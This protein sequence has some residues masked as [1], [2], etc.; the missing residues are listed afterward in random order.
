MDNVKRISDIKV[1]V[2]A[3]I[4]GLMPYYH[5]GD[6][7]MLQVAIER[8]TAITHPQNLLLSN[9]WVEAKSMIYGV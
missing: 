2:V 6:E 1:L 5:V 7:A 4:P 9:E 3:D 8:L